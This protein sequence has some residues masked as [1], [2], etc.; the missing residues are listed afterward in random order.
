MSLEDR[1]R[2]PEC[3]ENR[4]PYR[5]LIVRTPL[6]HYTEWANGVIK[7][8]PCCEKVIRN[9]YVPE[10]EESGVAGPNANWNLY[11][12]CE[13]CWKKWRGNGATCS[14]CDHKG[15][16]ER[17]MWCTN[18][19]DKT[20]TE[21]QWEC[22]RCHQKKK[23]YKISSDK[24]REMRGINSCVLCL[25]DDLVHDI[26]PEMS[27]AQLACIDHDHET[28]RVRGILCSACNKSEGLVPQDVMAWAARL[29]LYRNSTEESQ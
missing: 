15:D 13:Q 8:C 24:L 23:K 14:I 6:R 11:L 28:G 1:Y 3:I 10:G 22:D 19:S 27:N 12:F 7:H 21:Q 25:R 29:E 9:Y 18:H 4:I 17:V 26:S 2:T 20:R 16:G 5:K